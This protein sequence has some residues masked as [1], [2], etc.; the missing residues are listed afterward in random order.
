MPSRDILFLHLDTSKACELIPFVV[1]AVEDGLLTFEEARDLL[2][3][4]VMVVVKGD[5]HAG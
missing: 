2:E 5:A 1:E 4:Q 3:E